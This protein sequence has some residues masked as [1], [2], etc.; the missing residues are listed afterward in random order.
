RPDAIVM[1]LAMPRMDGYE[2]I[3]LLRQRPETQ[4]AVILASSASLSLEPKALA[5]GADDFLPKPVEANGLLD[6]LGRFLNLLWIRGAESEPSA[7]PTPAAPINRA[8]HRPPSPERVSVLLD[9]AVRGRI[10]Q[11]LDEARRI[12]EQGAASATWL[13]HL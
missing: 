12:E 11:V 10:R 1:D 6:K 3:G 9:L 7:R 4:K 2:A 8:A 13:G 5:A